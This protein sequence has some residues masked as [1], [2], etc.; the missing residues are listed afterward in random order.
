MTKLQFIHAVERHTGKEFREHDRKKLIRKIRSSYITECLEMLRK[1]NNSLD[2][3]KVI[4][5]SLGIS[6][7]SNL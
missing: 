6:L 4:R 3:Y 2:T 1:T 7:L 5:M